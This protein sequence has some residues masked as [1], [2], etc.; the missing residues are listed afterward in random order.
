MLSLLWCHCTSHSMSALT[1]LHSAVILSTI[2]LSLL[3]S[4]TYPH[5]SPY[6]SSISP[7]PLLPF[8]CLS[9]SLYPLTHPSSSSSLL[10]PPSSFYRT[11]WRR[12]SVLTRPVR[13]LL[14]TAWAQSWSHL[15]TNTGPTFTCWGVESRQA[16]CRKLQPNTTSDHSTSEFAVGSLHLC[17]TWEWSRAVT[18]FLPDLRDKTLSVKANVT[19]CV[20]NYVTQV[21]GQW[22]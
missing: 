4:S 17:G 8:P 10:P 21:T 5:H 14:H 20:V 16:R 2:P 11:R 1:S 13:L 9:L 22:R 19:L 12:S 18:R 3:L 15:H 7:P 6:H